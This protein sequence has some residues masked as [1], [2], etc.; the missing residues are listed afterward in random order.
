[1][2]SHIFVGR[3]LL[4]VDVVDEGL[5]PVNVDHHDLLTE[6]WWHWVSGHRHQLWDGW[7]M[8]LVDEDSNGYLC[9]SST[10]HRQDVRCNVVVADNVVDLET[11]ELVLELADFQV[12]GVHILLVAISRL[13]DLVDDHCRVVVDQ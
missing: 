5:S 9:A 1:L 6:P 7:R 3:D 13:V 2:F 12:V 8:K 4:L 10:K 11:V